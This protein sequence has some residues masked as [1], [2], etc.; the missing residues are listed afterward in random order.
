MAL[1][2]PPSDT[3]HTVNLIF[4]GESPRR[5]YSSSAYFDQSYDHSDY[6]PPPPPV[7]RVNSS[8]NNNNSHRSP[9]PVVRPTTQ[10]QYRGSSSSGLPASR[11]PLTP[12]IQQDYDSPFTTQ[13]ALS[14]PEFT[15]SAPSSPQQRLREPSLPR[16]RPR[17][18]VFSFVLKNGAANGFFSF[19]FY[20]CSRPGSLSARS[21]ASLFFS[22]HWTPH[23]SIFPTQRLSTAQSLCASPP[24]TRECGACNKTTNPT[25]AAHHRDHQTHQSFS[26][27][28]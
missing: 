2:S 21:N 20:F 25:V 11:I 5:H 24:S 6:P 14:P 26:A 18:Y 27:F 9:R 28:F 16:S 12:S 1:T 13:H 4:P 8:P 19:Y 7:P 23:D 22:S 3:G 15:S 17:T 10:N